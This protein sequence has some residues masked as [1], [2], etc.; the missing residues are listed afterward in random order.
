MNRK[1]INRAI[2]EKNGEKERYSSSCRV[3]EVINDKIF[4]CLSRTPSCNYLIPFGNAKYC[5]HPFNKEIA[6]Y[7]NQK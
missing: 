1:V 6:K 2:T 7:T 3:K 4:E 5:S